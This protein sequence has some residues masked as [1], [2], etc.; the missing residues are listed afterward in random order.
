MEVVVGVVAAVLLGTQIA[1]VPGFDESVLYKLMRYFCLVVGAL[2][3]A[4]KLRG[5]QA[6]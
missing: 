1:D 6:G 3:L 5:L 2:K 4:L